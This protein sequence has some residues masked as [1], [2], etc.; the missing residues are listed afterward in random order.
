MLSSRRHAA[1]TRY[2]NSLADLMNLSH[3]DI[4]VKED[5]VNVVDGGSVIA[6]STAGLNIATHVVSFAESFFT[7]SPEEQRNSV[8]HE[9]LHRHIDPLYRYIYGTSSIKD[10]VGTTVFALYEEIGGNIMEQVVD[11]ITNGWALLLPLP[12]R[13]PK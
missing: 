11:Q 13:F 12:P 10:Q 2:V 1:V 8:C 9:L 7:E 5:Y 3:Y 4:T 6:S